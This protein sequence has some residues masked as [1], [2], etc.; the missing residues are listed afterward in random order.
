M[1]RTTASTSATMTPGPSTQE[2]ARL[3]RLLPFV[4][5][6]AACLFNLLAYA[7]ELL[8]P[9]PSLN[10]DVFH[11][12]LAQRMDAAWAAGGDPLDP[13]VGYW[14]Q[15]FPVLRYYQHLP[16]FTTVLVHRLSGGSLSL[17]AA[18][19]GLRVLL[20]TLMPLSFYLGA[21]RLGAA[22]LAAAC[23][24]LCVPLLAAD[25]AARHFLG[26]Q[27]RS[28]LWSGS[29]LFPQLFAMAL[30]PLALGGA[31]RTALTG[32]G[33]APAIAWLAATWL[34]HL[35]LGYT[36]CLLGLLVLLHP[37][38]GGQRLKVASRLAA[39]Y[40]GTALVAAYL[41][42]P[43]LLESQWLSRSAWEPV[44][45]WDSYGAQRVLAALVTGGL[46]DG[47]RLPVLTLLAAIGAAFAAWTWLDRRRQDRGFAAL[48]LGIFVLGL[49]LFFGRPTWGRLL[50]VL[51]FS[52]SLPL[53]RFICAV[54]VGGI[55]LAGFALARLAEAADWSRSNARAALAGVAALVL[56]APAIAST[57][58]L[59]VNNARWRTEAAEAWA[60][61]GATVE[62][63]LRDFAALDRAAPGRGY[64]GASWDWGRDFKIG[65][66]NVYHRWTA[67]DLPAISYMYHTM[68]RLSDF[69]PY[70]DASRLDHHELFNVRYLLAPDSRGLPS[71]AER[72]AGAPDLAAGIVETK[73][74]FGVV[75]SAAFVPAAALDAAA[76]RELNRDFIAG[77]WHAANWFVRIG[78]ESGDSAVSGE[79]SLAPSDPV[80]FG[81]PPDRPAPHGGVLESSGA[82]DAFR[83]RVLLEEPG[84]VLFRMGF[85]PHWQARIGGLPARTLLLSPGYVGVP[86][87][88]G[89][90][91]LVMTYAPPEWTSW[92]RWTG[93][94]ILVLVATAEWWLLRSRTPTGTI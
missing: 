55:L 3:A 59:A 83:A 45:Y 41:L 7:A 16:H 21:R 57:A 26:F 69:E 66:V 17:P 36:A 33:Y 13:W 12:G 64:A 51:P 53:H 82:G 79:T 31:V 9:A 88:A 27:P 28:F 76:L 47:N 78:L 80:D 67:H 18:Y 93:L 2:T 8:M 38:A 50:E 91:E 19:D 44:E 29:G 35:V 84:I 75:G 70:F 89:E 20:L 24:A 40:L 92:L 62:S 37:E 63:A 11:L 14:G 65:S 49:L 48:A 73:G 15:G 72:R 1:L 81:T 71:F 39:I 85:H 87:P 25:P 58:S 60:T 34:S 43:T 54:Q 77:R 52:G 42:L 94:L 46:L 32:R 5:V 86:A 74:Y 56:L 10:D 6:A 23:V 68:G 4:F 61:T 22:R 90:H 30:F